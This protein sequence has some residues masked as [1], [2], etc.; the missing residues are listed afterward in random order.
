MLEASDIN[1]FLGRHHI[2]KDVSLRAE[3]GSFVAIIGPNGSGKTTLLRA[4]TAEIPFNGKATMNGID[5]GFAPARELATWRGV[6]PQSARLSFP[7][8]V[9]EVVRL[10]LTMGVHEPARDAARVAQALEAVDLSG[11]A[12]RF[13]QEL[14]GGEAQRVQLARVLAQ[15][16]EPVFE[17]R[18]RYLFLDEPISSLDIKHQVQIL[19]LA[20]DYAR[21]GGCVIAVL[22]D[23]NLAAHFADQVHLMSGGTLH[24]SGTSRDVMTKANLEA[25]YD[26]PMSVGEKPPEQQFFVLPHLSTDTGP[27]RWGSRH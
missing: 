4:L 7:F 1:I 26:C 8:T 10:G 6:L 20:L 24:A 12:G 15:V 18:P 23:L 21:A 3:P 14:S 9:H 27:D 17:G 13:Y 5:I 25:V 16:W 2:V 22:H 19:S 11:F